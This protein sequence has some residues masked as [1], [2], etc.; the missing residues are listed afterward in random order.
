MMKKGI[1]ILILVINTV[2]CYAQV[3]RSKKPEPAPAKEFEIGEYEKFTLKNG[4]TVIVVENRKLPRVAFSLIIDRE[5]LL[6]ENK[7]GYVSLAGEILRNGTTTRSKAQLDEEIDFIGASL[8]TSSTSIFGSSLTKHTDK[9]LDLF[10]DV[11]YNPA[12][13]QEELDKL[14]KQVI[15]G[16]KSNQDDPQAIL[17][18]VRAKLI[19]GED[20]P[21]GEIQLESHIEA[22]TISD[23]KGYYNTY[24]KPNIAYLAIVGDIN[25]NEAKKIVKKRFGNWAPGAVPQPKYSTPT[26]PTEN[27]VA[28]VNRTNAVQTVLSIGYPIQ[29]LPGSSQFIKAR[30]MNQVLGGGSAARLFKN[31]RE[32]K[33]YTYGAYS[34]IT[35]DELVGSFSAGASVRTEVTD[36]SVYEFLYE[37]RK[38][39]EEK[40][41][42]EELQLAK[43]VI[44]GGFG[45]SLERPQTIASFAINVERYN[46]PADYYNNYV[47]NV[48][49]VTADDVLAIARNYIKP[50]NTYITAVGKSS[51]IAK[52]LSKFGEVMYFDT[53]GNE[54]DPSSNKIPEGLT[55]KDV[56]DKYIE[57]I[58]G[59]RNIKMLKSLKMKMIGNVMGQEMIMDLSKTNSKRSAFVVTMAGNVVQKQIFDGQK[60]KSS[61]MA[62]EKV[63][64]GDE[65][66]DLSFEAA[67]VEELAFLE[68][69]L[70]LELIAVE[71]INGRDAYIVEVTTP[72][73]KALNRYYDTE[74][75]FL[76]R[77]SSPVKTSDGE[78]V[79][80]TDFDAYKAYQGVYFATKIRQPIN[81]QLKMD[82][83]LEEVLINPELDESIFVI[84]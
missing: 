63:I 31:I 32:D 59:V 19:Y 66:K 51:E 48:Q 9:L 57:A 60:G 35:P 40:V 27:I 25:V 50:E 43:N 15:S 4:L 44:I 49:S 39:T 28:L 7:V 37:M 23:L 36:S 46:L 78:M 45:R 75:G 14:K 77:V 11:L 16:I 68:E 76:V 71:N 64:E 20:H 2:L 13:K 33:A 1:L 21:Y 65:A 67:M 69:G 55:A 41:P 34:S 58:G 29:L 56:L 10:T 62:G 53:Y 70:P 24:F 54:V 8:S 80:S 6:E 26:L 17:S 82:I 38:M 83:T 3:D 18:N 72:S 79:L 12:F 52:G 5:P 61:G 81:Q 22:I 47:K 30:V 74:T 42:E 84:E 73:G